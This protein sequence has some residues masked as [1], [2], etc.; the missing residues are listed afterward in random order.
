M[1]TEK[2]RRKAVPHGFIARAINA[3]IFKILIKRGKRSKRQL[4]ENT[5]TR[6]QFR[7]SF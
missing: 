5:R 7:N 1:K 3:A 6:S 4:D 2:K